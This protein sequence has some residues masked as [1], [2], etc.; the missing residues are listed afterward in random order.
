MEGLAINIVRSMFLLSISL[1]IKMHA[2]RSTS[3]WFQTVSA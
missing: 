2:R 1:S 3:S